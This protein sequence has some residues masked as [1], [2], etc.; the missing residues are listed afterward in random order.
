LFPLGKKYKE[1]RRKT[2]GAH[3]ARPQ[4][5]KNRKLIF[6][7]TETLCPEKK[8]GRKTTSFAEE[9]ENP[10]DEKEHLLEKFGWRGK[11]FDEEPSSNEITQGEKKR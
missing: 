6:L 7:K 11:V 8:K 10:M 9:G 5:K 2:A 3:P 4:G 1:K